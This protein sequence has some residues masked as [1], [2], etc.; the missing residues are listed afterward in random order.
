MSLF[1]RPVCGG[2]LTRAGHACVCPGRHTFGIAIAF[3]IHVFERLQ[4]RK[5]AL[6]DAAV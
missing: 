6:H 5:G 1:C 2:P 4:G 3:D